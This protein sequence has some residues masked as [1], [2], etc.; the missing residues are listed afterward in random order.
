[1]RGKNSS[2]VVSSHY[3]FVNLL[4]KQGVVPLKNEKIIGSLIFFV[5]AGLFFILTLDFPTIGQPKDVGPAFMPK[6]YASFLVFFSIIL[7]IQGIRERLKKEN[8]SEPLYENM[9]VVVGTMI[10]TIIF[11]FL[12]PYLGFYLISIIFMMIFL[13]FTKVKSVWT[14]VFVSL[15]TNLFIFTFFEKMLNVPVPTGLLF[16]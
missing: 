9:A 11:V 8:D 1:M 13:K 3:S 15:G 12:I 7:L 5:F 14:I 10:L 2:I 6:V 16:S 4:G